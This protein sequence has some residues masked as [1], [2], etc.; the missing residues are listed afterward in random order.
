M[1]PATALRMRKVHFTVQKITT[2][3]MDKLKDKLNKLA[4]GISEAIGEAE[5]KT[6]LPRLS[7]PA[8][9]HRI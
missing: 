9:R 5:N 3:L 1:G 2:I 7:R 4:M 8:P 6:K